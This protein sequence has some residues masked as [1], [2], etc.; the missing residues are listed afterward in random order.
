[1]PAYGRIVVVRYPSSRKHAAFEV[2]STAFVPP[3]L[4]ITP[5]LLDPSDAEGRYSEPAWHYARNFGQ[6][7]HDRITTYLA[8]T[9]EMLHL[10]VMLIA[11]QM[12]YLTSVGAPVTVGTCVGFSM[13][14]V[15]H[16]VMAVSLVLSVLFRAILC[17]MLWDGMRFACLGRGWAV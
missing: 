13:W 15:L 5:L 10:I 6:G 14:E 3:C 9:Q 1:M 16:V 17:V 11:I 2:D 12:A 8:H 4:A 7:G